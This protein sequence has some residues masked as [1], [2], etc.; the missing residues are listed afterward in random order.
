MS[1][2]EEVFFPCGT[3]TLEGV[4]EFPDGA[5]D[6]AR[7]AVVCHPHPQYG[8]NM[9]NN[10]T[11]TVSDGL[12]ERGFACLRFNF[13]GV[14]R[15]QGRYGE[16]IDEIDDVRAALDFLARNARVSPDGALVA[17][18]S[19]GCW[20]ALKA[21]RRDSRPGLLVGISPPA[22]MYDF[23]FLEEE[24]RPKLLVTGD[25]DMFCSVRNF[26]KLIES[27]PEPKTGAV[28]DGSDHFHFGREKYVVREIDAFLDDWG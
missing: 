9:D 22:D 1:K 14:G 26:N 13:R 23:S 28:I 21:A 4:I 17:G 3:I 18:Y 7:A 15:S 27:I 25:R 5:S 11:A 10:V 19:F 24:K 12:L 2:K 8:G 6:S 20:V 16:G